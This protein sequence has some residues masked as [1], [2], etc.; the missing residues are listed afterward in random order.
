MI[1]FDVRVMEI[2]GIFDAYTERRETM[3]LEYQHRPPG[4]WNSDIITGQ[5]PLGGLAASST[6][7]YF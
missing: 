3:R 7:S 6:I 2:T 4:V 1:A 5:K